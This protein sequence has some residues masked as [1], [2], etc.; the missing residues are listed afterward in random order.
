MFCLSF[1]CK[2]TTDKMLNL[3]KSVIM[4]KSV[5]KYIYS[6]SFWDCLKHAFLLTAYLCEQLQHL[7]SYSPILQCTD[8]LLT[9]SSSA[10]FTNSSPFHWLQGSE[11]IS[12]G[13]PVCENNA[14]SHGLI[15][16]RIILSWDL[17]A[18]TNNK[19]K[20]EQW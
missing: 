17:E 2:R 19:N 4:N 13:I 6:L 5:V 9:H 14:W 3:N 16:K 1:V 8:T 12:N 10:L 7:G 20:K 18:Q 15:I 11:E